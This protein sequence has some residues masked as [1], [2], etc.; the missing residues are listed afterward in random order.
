M[1][2]L[3]I[4]EIHIAFST[5]SHKIR[6]LEEHMKEWANQYPG[7]YSINSTSANILNFEN[8]NRLIM[9]FYFEHTQNW[10]DPGGR[11]LRH[12]NFMMELKDECERLG[13]SYVLPS[14]PFES[15]KEDQ[16]PNMF[17][18]DDDD[19]N[20]NDGNHSG[21]SSAGEQAGARRHHLYMEKPVQQGGGVRGPTGSAG[22]TAAGGGSSGQ[23]GAA[24]G[25]AATV[26]FTT[27]FM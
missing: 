3:P 5:P 25:A 13:I 19:N 27:G 22:A 17:D 26:A 18:D 2:T 7:L 20:N 1:Y 10:Q 14:Q 6:Q 16:H 24:A 23:A 12:N 9:S 8:Q 21:E 11:W 4:L 15:N